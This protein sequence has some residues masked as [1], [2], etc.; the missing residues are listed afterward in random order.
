MSRGLRRKPKRSGEATTV[1]SRGSPDH[2]TRSRSVPGLFPVAGNAKS[3]TE[4]TEKA[5]F[6]VV[7]YYSV[8]GVPGIFY[9]HTSRNRCSLLCPIGLVDALHVRRVCLQNREHRERCIVS[10]AFS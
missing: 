3:P 7:D 8:P 10:L 4:M 5:Q 1:W 2:P 6:S 9:L